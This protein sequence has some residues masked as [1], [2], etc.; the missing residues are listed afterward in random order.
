M[1]CAPTTSSPSP[2]TLAMPLPIKRSTTATWPVARSG[3]RSC[4][5]SATTTGAPG[6]TYRSRQSCDLDLAGVTIDGDMDCSGTV[7]SDALVN[8]DERRLPAA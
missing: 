5:S 6:G 2:L 7:F 1:F 8:F 4:T 3:T